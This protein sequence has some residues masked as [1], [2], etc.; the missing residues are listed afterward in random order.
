MSKKFAAITL[1]L[2]L[3]F[4]VV[5]SGCSSSQQ[6]PQTALSKAAA[7]ALKMTSYQFS[8]TIKV[9]EIELG[10]ANP[11]VSLL[12]NAEIHVDGVYQNDPMQTEMRVDIKLH[13][14]TPQTITMPIIFTKDKIYFKY[15]NIPLI[16]VPDTVKDK[17]IVMDLA[18]ATQLDSVINPKMIEPKTTL[19]LMSEMTKVLTDTYD[20]KSYFK[21]IDPKDA[22]LPAGVEA[23]QVIQFNVGNENAKEAAQLFVNKALPKML[24]IAAKDE[25]AGVIGKTP[26]QIAE[27]NKNVKANSA[28]YV[29][30]VK[31]NLLTIKSAIDANDFPSYQDIT[32]NVE[33]NDP[34]TNKASKLSLQSTS[35]Y[36]KIN[37]KQTFA[38][39]IPKDTITL[40][41]FEQ[42]MKGIG[43]N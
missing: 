9:N 5:L 2:L 34:K 27:W 23:K 40:E 28:K 12:K 24:D 16:A 30:N 3:T 29:D 22:A 17:F 8:N 1:T 38:T 36:T 6:G 25:Y 15:P 7:N 18:E 11:L 43:V 37:E 13:G 10:S 41:Q 19:A 35:Q 42:A 20:G 39:G 14:Q 26:E 33:L 21:E 4:M 32:L 31:V